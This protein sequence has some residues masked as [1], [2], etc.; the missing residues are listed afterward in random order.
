MKVTIKK[1]LLEGEKLQYYSK[2]V[3]CIGFA[4]EISNNSML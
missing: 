2:L 3:H 1:S 4:T